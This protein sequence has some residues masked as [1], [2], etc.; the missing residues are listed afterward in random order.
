MFSPE[1]KVKALSL[2]AEARIIRQQTR[3]SVQHKDFDAANRLHLHRV[4][5]V[6]SVARDTHLARAYLKGM[7]YQR[8]EQKAHTTPNLKA[9]ATMVSKYGGA[10]WI[11]PRTKESAILKGITEADI[12]AWVDGQVPKHVEVDDGLGHVPESSTS[13]TTST[14]A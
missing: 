10:I 1:L 11:W 8:V 13:A 5:I 9:I 12:Q 14:I 3:K 2:A 6:R 4:G 7:P